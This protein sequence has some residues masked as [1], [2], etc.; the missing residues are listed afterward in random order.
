M[1]PLPFCKE[2]LLMFFHDPE[3]LSCIRRAHINGAKL[4]DEE[5]TRH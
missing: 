3:G 1:E 4:A 2:L 5:M